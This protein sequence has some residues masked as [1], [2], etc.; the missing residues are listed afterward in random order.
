MA[1]ISPKGKAIL[2]AFRDLSQDEQR[3]VA[4]EVVRTY[5]QSMHHTE[6]MPPSPG[7]PGWVSWRDL[8]GLFS[9]GQEPPS[10]ELVAQ[11]LD[12]ARIEKFGG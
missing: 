4:E 1:A 10:D 7:Q 9:N 8:A 11:W 3:A 6:T 12:E 2:D 5:V